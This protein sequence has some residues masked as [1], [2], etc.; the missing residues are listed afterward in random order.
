M[1]LFVFLLK[2]GIFVFAPYVVCTHIFL[3]IL[4]MLVCPWLVHQFVYNL[5]QIE[6]NNL[7]IRNCKR[8]ELLL[9]FHMVCVHNHN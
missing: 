7:H 1:Q 5:G 4:M 3:L 8:T 2:W 9:C 6:R